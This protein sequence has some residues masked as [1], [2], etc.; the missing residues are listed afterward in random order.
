[1]YNLQY[2]N[3]KATQEEIFE[4]ARKSDIH[5][6]IM[7]MPKKYETIVGERGLKLSGGEKQRVAITRCLLKDPTIFVYDEATS[8]LDS[9]TEK[10]ILNSLKANIKGRTSIFIAHRLSTITDADE[11]IVLGNGKVIEKGTHVNLITQPSSLYFNL[12]QKQ[13]DKV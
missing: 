6:A 1:M 11:I 9:I 12:W 8:S 10:N 2:G 3:L 7:K 13:N 4:A 5:N